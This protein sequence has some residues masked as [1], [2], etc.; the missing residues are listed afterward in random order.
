ML[1]I[2]KTSNKKLKWAGNK[3]LNYNLVN[4]FMIIF[5]SWYFIICM[6]KHYCQLHKEK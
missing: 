6:K 5:H 1:Y 4:F 2:A 3:T